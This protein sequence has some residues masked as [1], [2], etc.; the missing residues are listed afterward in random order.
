[1]SI[2]SVEDAYSKLGT[3]V[4]TFVAGRPWDSAGCSMQIYAS[5]ARGAQWLRHGN[6]LDESG[7]FDRNPGAIWEGLDAALFLRDDLLKTTGDQIW[8]LT[9]TLY[10]TGKFKIEYSYDKPEGYVED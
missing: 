1:M 7:G 9:F 4:I 3:Y 5:M 6:E 2:H 8:G 10:P